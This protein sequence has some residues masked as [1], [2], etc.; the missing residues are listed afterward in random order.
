MDDKHGKISMR[1]AAGEGIRRR[2]VHAATDWSISRRWMLDGI[3]DTLSP[4]LCIHDHMYI[5]AEGWVSKVRRASFANQQQQFNT[6]IN[7][8]GPLHPHFDR[9]QSPPKTPSAVRATK[10]EAEGVGR[11]AV[12]VGHCR[13][14]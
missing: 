6:M 2:F 8:H 9:C 3:N 1:G 4:F 5:D 12:L 13:L 11:R 14:T 7:N 10:A